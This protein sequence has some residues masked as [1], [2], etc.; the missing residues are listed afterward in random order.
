MNLTQRQIRIFR[1]LLDLEDGQT[2]STEQLAAKVRV[3]RRTLFRE[4]ESI[5]L[6]LEQY[7]L[8]L[9]RRPGLSLNGD[10]EKLARA[11]D[12][13]QAPGALDKDERQDMLLYELLRA[14]EKEKLIVYAARFQVSE[15]TISHD[16]EDLQPRLDAW[17]LRLS[18][19]GTI[20]GSEDARRRA[21]AE[22]VRD[23]VEYKTVDYLDPDTVLEQIFNGSAIFSLLNQDILK[24]ILDLFSERREE[25]GLS[26][27]EQNSYIGLVIHLVIAL[28]RIQA[29]E[30][31]SERIEGLPDLEESRQEARKITSL[32]EDEF[33]LTFPE[34]EIDAIALH[35]R[36]AKVNAATGT[37]DHDQNEILELAR[38]FVE[39]FPPGDAA[40]LST[41]P[42]FIQGLLSHLEPTVIR[43]KKGLPI[44]N[45]LLSSLKEQYE[46]LFEKTRNAAASIERTLSLPLSDEEIGFLTM[47]VGAC[48]ERSGYQYR[49]KIHAAVVCA[50]GIGVSALLRARLDKAFSS[51]MD[52]ENLSLAQARKRAD[53]ELFIT[54]FYPGTLPAPFIQV[55]PMLPVSDLK[56]IQEQL[57]LMQTTPAPLESAQAGMDQ[58]LLELEE[59]IQAIRPLLNRIPIIHSDRKTADELIHEAASVFEGDSERLERDLLTREQLGPVVDP[60]EGFGLFH[61]RSQG[62][63]KPQVAVLVPDDGT[64]HNGL[65]VI[66]VTILP[67]QHTKAMQEALSE[68]NVALALDPAFRNTLKSGPDSKRHEALNRILSGYLH[69]IQSRIGF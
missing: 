53:L 10:R 42:Q 1:T 58:D 69:R 19:D 39:S 59:A 24:R 23:G 56:K 29:G 14:E 57:A 12:T 17:D 38:Q 25:L 9:S 52:L 4:L 54:T 68:L 66:L 62:T 67:E 27:Y 50:S 51:Q 18:K 45:P 36:G 41:D 2:I 46:A 31:A 63:D 20:E 61:T 21:M 33:E 22:L 47:H 28:E 44:Y 65:Q 40:L 32:L 26:R 30:P 13:R 55:S 35:L 49:R 6:I 11:L 7:G 37:L 34:S 15:A 16:L 5:R 60:D 43:L 48:F 64:F 8:S 3:S